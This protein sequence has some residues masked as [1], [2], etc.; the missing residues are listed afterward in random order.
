MKLMAQ[1]DRHFIRCGIREGMTIERFVPSEYGGGDDQVTDEATA[2]D[3]VRVDYNLYVF[4]EE[5]SAYSFSG[6]VKTY[7]TQLIGFVPGSGLSNKAREFV[8]ALGT[9]FQKALALGKK[10]TDLER[11]L[12]A[13]KVIVLLTAT[14]LNSKVPISTHKHTHRISTLADDILAAVQRID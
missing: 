14:R 8:E 9:V 3:I 1:M 4:P 6:L 13:K 7:G 10:K 12:D 11:A 5:E 2:G